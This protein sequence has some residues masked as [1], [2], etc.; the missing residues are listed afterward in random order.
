MHPEVMTINSVFGDND[1][2]KKS[3]DFARNTTPLPGW[4]NGISSYSLWWIILHRDYYLHQGDLAYLKEQ[5]AYLKKLVPQIAAKVSDGKENLDGGRF[6]DWP[7][8]KNDEVIHS[9]LQAL[10]LLA[11]EAGAVLPGVGDQELKTCTTTANALRNIDIRQR[12]KRAP[13]IAGRSHLTAKRQ[14]R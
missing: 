8:A 5:Q 7:T 14:P 11:M 1:V 12:N 2:V 10:S 9:G 4:M 13:Y 3:L 6:L